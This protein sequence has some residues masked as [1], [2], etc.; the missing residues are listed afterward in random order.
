MRTR[1]GAVA[2]AIM[3]AAALPVGAQ[4]TSSPEIDLQFVRMSAWTAPDRPLRI[5]AVLSNRG[6]V[7]LDGLTVGVSI[8]GRVLSRSELRAALDGRPRGNLV[9]VTTEDL[10]APLP[11]GVSQRLDIDRDLGALAAAFRPP[12]ARGG[13]YPMVMTVQDERA[14]LGRW[15]AAVPFFSNP[16]TQRLSVAWIWTVHRP[17]PYDG[18][19]RVDS[20]RLEADLA[21]IGLARA[22]EALV[23]RPDAR[24]TVAVSGALLDAADAVVRAA[25]ATEAP[26]ESSTAPAA[27]SPP[28]APAP[29]AA[30]LL[31][32]LRALARSPNIEMAA[33]PYGRAD[34]T[35]LAAHGLERDAT[36]QLTESADAGSRILGV[37]PSLALAV[38]SRFRLDRRSASLAGALGARRAVLD[39][40]LLPPVSD[41]AVEGG[42]FGPS[43]PVLVDA[44]PGVTMQALLVDRDIRERLGRP[45]DPVL[46]AQGI[47]AE[48]ASSFFELPL[49]AGARLLVVAT[50]LLPGAGTAT[51]LLR[52]LAEAPWVQMRTAGEAIDTLEAAGDSLALQ[53][54]DAAEPAYFSSVRAARRTVERIR[55]VVVDPAPGVAAVDRLVLVAESVDWAEASGAGVRVAEAAR[56]R[57]QRVLDAIRAPDR[58]V[59]LTSRK[60]ALPVTILNGTGLGVRVRVVLLSA[61]VSF[62]N[63]ETRTLETRERV[64]TLEFPAVALATG[65]F[66]VTVLIQTPGGETIGTASIVVR[67]TAVGAVALAATGGGVVFLIGAWARRLVRRRRAS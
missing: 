42:L 54:A 16:P 6:G 24:I 17:P 59:T 67:S 7:P 19:G 23:R 21:R 9:A 34:L 45:G 40:T 35:E 12:N 53:P 49:L 33:L 55:S 62:P 14:T 61:K 5:S 13:V 65:S 43:R 38:P 2:A 63:G 41:P 66:P 26:A 51:V 4:D 27:S 29:L 25:S 11:P 58:I 15:Y 44:A 52:A 10:G 56:E 20:P 31:T 47:V 64:S 3:L 30:R 32:G 37:R 60:G 8:Y 18:E 22:V 50:D 36:R 28:G 1:L 57:G 39:P 48:T 46:R